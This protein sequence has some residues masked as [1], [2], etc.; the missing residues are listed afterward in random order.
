MATI[1]PVRMT[2]GTYALQ[3]DR[4]PIDWSEE[5]Y[6]SWPEVAPLLQITG[7]SRKKAT[8]DPEFSW[9]EEAEGP[10]TD[11]INNAAG[12]TATDVQLV[13]DHGSYFAAY[14][15]V[16]VPRTGEQML[17]T[18]VDAVTNTLTVKRGFGTTGAAALVDNDVLLIIGN[19]MP[20][21][22]GKPDKKLRNPVP[23][24][25][26]TQ[27]FKTVF[28]VSGTVAAST[29][30]GPK[31][32]AHQ[33]MIY[34]REHKLK[35]E[36]AALFGEKNL[37]VVNSEVVRSTQGLLATIQTHVWNAN[38]PLTEAAFDKEF[39]PMCFAR[40]SR[41]KLAL[42]GQV[43]LA[44]IN[45]WAKGRIQTVSGSQETYGISVSR[46]ITPFGDLLLVYDELLSG[47]VYGGYII[48]VDLDNCWYRPLAGRDTKLYPNIQDPDTDAVE[49][50]YL[51]EAGFEFRCEETF[52]LAK[53]ITAA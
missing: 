31:E 21:A 49:E 52:A 2:K 48:V 5:I 47:P 50:M 22:S 45:T 39:V 33:R 20:E 12:Y 26:Y 46:Y 9:F 29:L 3:A 4:L 36:Y 18:A 6:N 16:K 23:K 24:S 28:G 8:N 44:Q 35:L 10:V 27:I 38:G 40:G 15:V 7:K 37:S 30:R 13:V 53:G 43:P 32:L 11:A 41:K 34:N 1:A 17:V 42:C 25:N 51:T 14:D 19:A